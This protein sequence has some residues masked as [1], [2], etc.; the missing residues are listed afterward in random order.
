MLGQTSIKDEA[1]SDSELLNRV[2]RFKKKFY[3]NNS[4]KYEEATTKKLKLLPKE[5]TIKHLQQDYQVMEPMF[6]EEPPA[7]EEIMRYLQK[8]EQEIHDLKN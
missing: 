1:L 3:L 8:L 2:V 6:F 7:F 4:A 5:K